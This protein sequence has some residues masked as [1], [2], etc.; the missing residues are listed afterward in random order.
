MK[1]DITTLRDHPVAEVNRM[2]NYQE[3]EQLKRSLRDEGQLEHITVYRDK[4]IVD[5]RNRVA[6]A[7]ALGWTYLDYTPTKYHATTEEL[8]SIA[9]RKETRRMQSKTELAMKAAFQLAN[10]LNKLTQPQVAKDNA[11]SERLVKS[12]KY[13]YLNHLEAAQSFF[14]HGLYSL[15]PDDTF[16]SLGKYESYLRNKI[17]P[18]PDE[19]TGDLLDAATQMVVSNYKTLTKEQRERAMYVM[20]T[21][22]TKGDK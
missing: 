21:L 2:M 17:R 7:L 4:L 15:T 3:S 11:V 19:T 16:Y 13:I 5:G 22:P 6:Q 9:K 18:E 12:A 20:S 10:P 8:R 1:I 14:D